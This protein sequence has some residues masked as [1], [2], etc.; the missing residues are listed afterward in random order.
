M[1]RRFFS[2]L[3]LILILLYAAWLLVIDYHAWTAGGL[4]YVAM[5]FLMGLAE[6]KIVLAQKRR[7]LL[8]RLL[9]DRPPCLSSEDQALLEQLRAKKLF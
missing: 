4:T 8:Q 5:V 1:K 6:G 7:D 3:G 2:L 9:D